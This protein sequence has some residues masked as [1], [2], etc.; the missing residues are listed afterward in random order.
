[1]RIVIE[2]DL[3][4]EYTDPADPT[5]VTEG[6]YQALFDRLSSFG[7]AIDIRLIRLA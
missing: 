6:A 4:D 2:L 1:M 5:G 7:D 3:Y